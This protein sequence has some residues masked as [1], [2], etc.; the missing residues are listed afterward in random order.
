LIAEKIDDSRTRYTNKVT[1]HPTDAFMRFIEDHGVKYEDAAA[2]Q[3]CRRRPQ[4]PGDTTVRCKHR[5][6]GTFEIRNHC[7][8]SDHFR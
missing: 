3:F 4:Q 2:R 1:T 8:E 5:P 7:D 6:A